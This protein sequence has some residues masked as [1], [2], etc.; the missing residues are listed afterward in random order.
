MK[1]DDMNVQRTFTLSLSVMALA[2]LAACAS[3]SSKPTVTRESRVESQSPASIPSRRADSQSKILS[4]FSQYESALNAAK[5]GD[6]A[7]AQQYLAQAGNSAMAETVRNEWLKSLGSR[8]QWSVF[9]QEYKKLEAAGRAQ[10][11]ECYADLSSGN[12]AK[13]ADL[14]RE[15]ARLPQ[16][17]TRLVEAAA[18]SGRLNVDDA[19]RRVRGLLSNNQITDA[20]NLAALIG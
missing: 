17:C 1:K 4:D 9:Q 19:W 15:T 7:W 2:V 8:G 20:R 11:V 13:A 10:E 14:V 18:A 16:G 6:D 3:Q 5:R 12:Y